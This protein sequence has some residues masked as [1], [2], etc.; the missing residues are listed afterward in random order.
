MKNRSMPALPCMCAN[1][2][3]A[4]RAISQHY[5]K[6]MR[7]TGLTITQFTVLQALTLTG[8]VPQGKLGEILSMDSTTL[9]RTLNIMRKHVWIASRCGADRRERRLSLSPAGKAE[10]QRALPHWQAAQAQ[11]HARIGNTRWNRLANLIH[12]VTSVVAD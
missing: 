4:S 8:E 5:D 9:T 1:L 10:F 6:A 3:R 11:L 2:R 12:E 7:P